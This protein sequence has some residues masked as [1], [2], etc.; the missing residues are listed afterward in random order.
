MSNKIEHVFDNVNKNIY[1]IEE[2]DDLYNNSREK[3]IKIKENLVCFKCQK[4]KIKFCHGY[5]KK[6]YFASIKVDDHEIMCEY[7][8]ERMTPENFKDILKNP[9]DKSN[10]FKK[11]DSELDKLFNQLLSKEENKTSQVKKDNNLKKDKDTEIVKVFSYSS[12]NKKNHSIY[13]KKLKKG[14]FSDLDIGVFYNFYGEINIQFYLSGELKNGKPNQVRC[15]IY[16]LENKLITSTFIFS[17]KIFGDD[18]LFS[19]DKIHQIIGNNIKYTILFC[20]S[21]SVLKND[22][23]YNLKVENQNMKMKLVKQ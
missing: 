7:F 5:V 16:D 3:A 23:F 21:A 4:A 14:C 17:N 13:Q 18:K 20:I 1:S 2:F 22:K 6:S 15:L 19:E 10:F 8:S 9:L 11:V 12:K